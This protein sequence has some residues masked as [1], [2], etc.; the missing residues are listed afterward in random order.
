[1]KKTGASPVPKTLILGLDG[2]PHSL[3]ANY[4]DKGILPNFKNILSNGFRLI[5]METSIPDVSSVSWTSFMTGVNPGEHG[6]FGFMDMRPN[7][8]CAYFTNS[9]DIQAPAL[10]DIIGQTAHEKNSTLLERYRGR[11]S[12]PFKS[13]VLNI[14]QTYPAK[15]LNG[16]MTAGFVCT[17]LKKGTYPDSAHDYLESIGYI[18]D[19]NSDMATINRSAFFNEIFLALEKRAQAFE[20]FFKNEPWDLFAAV[21]TETDRLHHF[22]F[23]AANDPENPNHAVFVSFYR[24]MDE[25][26]GRLFDLFMEKTRGSGLF[27]TISDHGFT[28]L[29]HEV[30]VNPFLRENG[31][32]KIND[33]KEY[34]ERIGASTAAFSLEP[35]RVYVNLKGKYP[36]GSIDMSGRDRVIEDLKCAFKS[37][38]DNRGN[39]VMKSVYDKNELYRGPSSAKAPDIVCIANDGYD[40]KSGFNKGRILGKG[41][42][43]G[44]HTQ[45]DAH[46]IMP[47]GM[48]HERPLHIEN[49]AGH[50]LDYFTRGLHNV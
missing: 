9:G 4:I 38:T 5:K 48:E 20:H 24:R 13:V 47:C 8:Y 17:D 18:P 16:V 43:T 3:I 44:M 6:I 28:L 35:A 23:D 49:I 26:V 21:I 7:T 1:M 25:I 22:F 40:L 33:Q 34:L 31:F 32:L 37:L 10:W 11:F 46:C 30:Y 41:A 14:P 15:K 50:I 19:V 29:N 27:M 42:F 45:H 12:R 39:S 36:M 2:V